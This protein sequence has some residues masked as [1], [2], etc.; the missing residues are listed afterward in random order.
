MAFQD[1]IHRVTQFKGES[2]SET[3]AS[4]E[5]KLPGKNAGGVRLVNGSSGIEHDLLL[6][7][8][9]VKRASVQIDVVIH[10]VGILYTLPYLLQDGEVVTSVH[11]GAGN[12]AGDFHLVTNQRLAQFKFAK[13]AG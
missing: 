5:A 9:A 12:A 11:L 6:N 3:I 10:A 1:A 8:A 7:V 4:I 13:V 2:L